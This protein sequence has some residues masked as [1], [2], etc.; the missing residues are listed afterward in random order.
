[1]Y[2]CAS[3]EKAQAQREHIRDQGTRGTS[4]RFRWSYNFDNLFRLS[5]ITNN[6]FYQKPKTKFVIISLPSKGN[7]NSVT[8]GAAALS[9]VL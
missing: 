7:T 1:M 9:M 8:E 3:A 2:I 4:L 6:L 5:K